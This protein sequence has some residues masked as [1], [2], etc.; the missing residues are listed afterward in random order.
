MR[1]HSA[2]RYFVKIFVDLVNVA[3]QKIGVAT[4]QNMKKERLTDNESELI[5]NSASVDFN[6]ILNNLNTSIEK[7]NKMFDLNISFKLNEKESEKETEEKET[8]EKE[9]SQ[10]DKDNSGG[11]TDE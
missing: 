10:L 7:A 1:V 6:Y 4:N 2:P 11:D 3:N 5:E 9:S 8:E